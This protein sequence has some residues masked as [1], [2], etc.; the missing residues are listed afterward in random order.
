MILIIDS[1]SFGCIRYVVGTWLDLVLTSQ[2]ETLVTKY[3]V[4]I[5]WHAQVVGLSSVM[6]FVMVNLTKHSKYA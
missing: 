6:M 4:I 2:E 1:T 5:P 3:D